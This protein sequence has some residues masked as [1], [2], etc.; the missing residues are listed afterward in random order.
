M[1]D[2]LEFALRHACFKRRAAA[3][4]AASREIS[5]PMQFS[6]YLPPRRWQ[7]ANV[8]PCLCLARLTCTGGPSPGP[9][10]AQQQAAERAWP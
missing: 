9:G 4:T 8:L 10:R 1:S 2:T 3:S 7:V 5:L 6:V